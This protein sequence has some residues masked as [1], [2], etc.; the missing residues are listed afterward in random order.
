MTDAL[1]HPF[2]EGA[3]I[4][5][6]DGNRLVDGIANLWCC[7]IGH[8]RREVID[9]VTDQLSRL[10]CYNTF[11][12]FTNDVAVA[13]AERIRSWSPLG[14]GRVFLGSGGSD[15]ID[16]ALKLVRAHH[17]RAGDADRQVVLTRDRGYHGTNLGGTSVQGLV[18][19]PIA[20]ALAVCPPA[21]DPRRGPRPHRRRHRCR[22]D[23]APVGVLRGSAQGSTSSGGRSP[24]AAR[25]GRTSVR[26]MA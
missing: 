1:L 7:Q 13:A 11:E 19:R 3:A 10:D 9:A 6:A 12:P 23:R 16:T 14:D 2:A 20:Q 21:H 8:G 24:A 22:P 5:T 18:V 26:Q 25:R 4:W 17:Q 15:A